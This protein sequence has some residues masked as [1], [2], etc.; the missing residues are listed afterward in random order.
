M[1]GR[2]YNIRNVVLGVI[3]ADVHVVGNRILDHALRERGFVTTNLGIQVSQDDFIAAAI[4]TNAAVILVS[5]LYGH[6]E[7]D[8]RGFRARCIERGIG[9]ILLYL[10]G[11]LV[12]GK[13]DFCEV[14]KLFVDMGFSRVFSADVALEEALS[15][16]EADLSRVGRAGE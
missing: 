7:L 5:S 15:Q 11:N 8:C 16:L 12:V 3:G 2:Q 1:D 10:G 6:A 9:D 4:E 13:H 14:E